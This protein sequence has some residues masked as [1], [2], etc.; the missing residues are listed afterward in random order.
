MFEPSYKT[1]HTKLSRR[2]P[3][4]RGQA[5]VE[6]ALVL[7]VLILL[8]Y[9][10]VE[11][12]RL[13]FINSE[14]DNAA[15]EAAHYASLVPGAT[16]SELLSVVDSKLALADHNAVSVAGPTYAGGGARCTFCTMT[17]T[18][19]YQWTTLV[20]ILKLGPLT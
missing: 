8:I 5:T 15:R 9:G 2:P 18:V 13:V 19:D 17:V 14:I 6:F 7:T 12:S 3:K 4:A 1:D 16:N 11:V 20:P 10:V